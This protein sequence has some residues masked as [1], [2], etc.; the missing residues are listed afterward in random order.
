[1]LTDLPCVNQSIDDT[2]MTT[3]CETP[4]SPT[5]CL[6]DVALEIEADLEFASGSVSIFFKFYFYQIM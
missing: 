2:M 3:I 5:S 1:M 4:K 6:I